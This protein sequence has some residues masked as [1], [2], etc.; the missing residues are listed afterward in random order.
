MDRHEK[1][2]S[3]MKKI[4]EGM[5]DM[6]EDMKDINKEMDKNEGR[7]QVADATWKL[8]KRLQ[9]DLSTL[10]TS[11]ARIAQYTSSPAT[12][13]SVARSV[14]VFATLRRMVC[15]IHLLFIIATFKFMAE[16]FTDEFINLSAQ[17][18]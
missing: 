16:Y 7:D 10:P 5:K 15:M 2:E 1:M 17:S 9:Q 4:E 3:K 12:A 8:V 11:S 18:L 6:K 13:L 14:S